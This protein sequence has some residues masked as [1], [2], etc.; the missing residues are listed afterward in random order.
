MDLTINHFKRALQGR[1]N[2]YGLRVGLPDPICAEIAASAGYDWLMIDAEHAPFTIRDIQTYLSVIASY[3]VAPVI[4]PAE[5][6]GTLL[7]QLLDV[8]AQTI[9]VPMVD[10]AEEAEQ[11]VRTLMFPPQGVRGAGVSVTRAARWKNVPD[12]IARAN[13]EICLVVQAETVTAMQ[14]IEG[15]ASV[16]GVDAVFFGPSDLAASMGYPGKAECAEVVAEIDRGIDVVLS[17]NKTAGIFAS[18]PELANH[19][20]EK[21]V[22]FV[23]LG[24]DTSLLSSAAASLLKQFN[25][26][27]I[28]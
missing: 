23:C 12:Y 20:L 25:P 21:G 18:T 13:D 8:G 7:G 16:E 1:K 10:S 3:P 6:T 11:I 9:M 27:A 2:Q 17:V 5:G 28:Q 14:N 4:R 22:S 19:Y 24:A 15:I 26:H